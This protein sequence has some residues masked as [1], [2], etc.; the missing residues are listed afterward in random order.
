MFEVW[1]VFS[2]DFIAHFTVEYVGE[3]VDFG[4]VTGPVIDSPE[5]HASAEEKHSAI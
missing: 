3:S 5:R 1:W 4:K 2:K